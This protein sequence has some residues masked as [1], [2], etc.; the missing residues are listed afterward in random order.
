MN[1]LTGRIALFLLAL[2]VIVFA[3]REIYSPDLGFHIRTGNWILDNLKFPGNDTFTYTSGEKSYTDLHWIFQVYSALVH[4]LSGELGLVSV[5]ALLTLLSFAILLLRIKGGRALNEIG[6][7]QIIG[8]LAITSVAVFFEQRPHV[9]SWLYFNLLLLILENMDNPRVGGRYLFLM[10]VILLIWVNTHSL[11]VLGLVVI[12]CYVAGVTY[13]D[14][15]IPSKL[16]FFS[17]LS[18]GACFL[19]PYHLKG[20]MLPLQQFGLLQNNNVFK[21]AISELAPS[22]SMDGYFV[23]GRFVLLQPLLWFH[24]FAAAGFLAFL[25]R[26]R[27]I[28]LQEFVIFGLFLYLALSAVRNI[29]FFV[30]AVAPGVIAGLRFSLPVDQAGASGRNIFRRGAIWIKSPRSEVYLNIGVILATSIL[31]LSLV[32]NLY[33]MNYRSNDRFGYRFNENVL[34]VKAAEFLNRNNLHGKILN[35]FNFGGFLIYALPQK[36]FI[37]GRTE[38]MGEEIFYRYSILWNQIDK[39]PII[40]K[41]S[42]DIIIFP[43]QNE[44]LWVHYL[45]A[46]SIWRLA[47]LDPLAAIYL[48]KGYAEGVPAL[49]FNE[50][51]EGRGQADAGEILKSPSPGGIPLL[52]LKS[53]YFPLAELG[54]STFHYYNDRFPEAIKVG[55]DGLSRSTVDC[56]EMYYNLG[57]Y[58]FEIRDFGNAAYCYSRFLTSSEDKL[59]S[60]RLKMIRS[61]SIRVWSDD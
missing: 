18:L 61:G 39:R 24:I 53:H 42:P 25:R 34:P 49:A 47:H 3:F 43:H 58:Y 32:T 23:N 57:H 26:I 38:V 51:D 12:A 16:L 21:N 33:Y 20:V 41:Y 48:R 22:L 46:D 36:V 37:D 54:L 6:Y 44:F 28:G 10:P 35:H 14:R 19:N 40:E 7:W 52:Q 17:L 29:G 13:R 2:L 56:P 50:A 59:A 45:R 31:I 15:K 11:F 60:E 55:L 5:N 8:F 4:K 1:K 9:L 27:T 30:F